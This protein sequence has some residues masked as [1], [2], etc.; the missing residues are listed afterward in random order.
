MTRPGAVPQEAWAR[1]RLIPLRVPII[2]GPPPIIPG[3]IRNVPWFSL[4][5]PNRCCPAGNPG[6]SRAESPARGHYPWTDK[7]YP[8]LGRRDIGAEPAGTPVRVTPGGLVL[9]RKIKNRSE[10]A[11]VSHFA[12]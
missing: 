3:R 5:V 4:D 6:H 11:A 1:A 12:Y 10:Q 7:D 8:A 9:R 2:L